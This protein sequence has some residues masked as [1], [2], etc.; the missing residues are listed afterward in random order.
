M[1]FQVI[2]EVIQGH[3]MLCYYKLFYLK[4]NNLE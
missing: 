2:F 4:Y 3:Y 1:L